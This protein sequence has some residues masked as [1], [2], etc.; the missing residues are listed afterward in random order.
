MNAISI[1]NG[2]VTGGRRA[3]HRAM[4][5]ICHHDPFAFI[6]MIDATDCS[7]GG[8]CSSMEWHT[9]SGVPVAASIEVER[10]A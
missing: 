1:A 2:T 10:T 7:P 6:G 4:L 5:R 3:V 9:V 8:G